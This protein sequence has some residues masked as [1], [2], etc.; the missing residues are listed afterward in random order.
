MPATSSRDARHS[1]DAIRATIIQLCRPG[2][3]GGAVILP[4]GARS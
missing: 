1:D 3:Y 2:G 4:A